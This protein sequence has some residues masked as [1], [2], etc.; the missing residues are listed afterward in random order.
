[1][2]ITDEIKL[3][4]KQLSILSRKVYGIREKESISFR[5]HP[6]FVSD[7]I[8]DMTNI[9]YNLAIAD[10]VNSK[11]EKDLL[12]YALKWIFYPTGNTNAKFLDSIGSQFDNFD[13]NSP[14]VDSPIL[15]IEQA[16]AYD[17]KNKDNNKEKLADELRE[18]VVA[19]AE[20]LV[21]ADGFQSV[22]EFDVLETF[23]FWVYD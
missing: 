19:Y 15:M 22:R 20:A 11:D 10:H 7:I 1:M 2:F 12:L 6:K 14:E 8:K 16:K 18:L 21:M 4:I 3:K 5:K 13:T 17:L 9:S 23:K